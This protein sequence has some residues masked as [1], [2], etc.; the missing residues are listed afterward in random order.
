MSYPLSFCDLD[1]TLFQTVR[2][3]NSEPIRTVTT[4]KEAKP[5]SVMTDTQS[6]FFEWLS[7]TT[8]LIPITARSS[9]QFKRLQLPF[10]SWAVLAHGAVIYE[11]GGNVDKD[12]EAKIRHELS[13]YKDDL[14]HFEKGFAAIAESLLIEVNIRLVSEYDVP[15]YLQIKH[16][17]RDLDNELIVLAQA[18]TDQ[19]NL[20]GFYI[21][22][23]GNNLAIIPD[24]VN[25]QRAMEYVLTKCQI[26]R[27]TD[28]FP[29]LGF[30]DSISDLAFMTQCQWVCIPASSQIASHTLKP[31]SKK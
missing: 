2:K 28:K 1:D 23:N 21:H 20:N 25:K 3:T 11:P 5:Q 7:L 16:Q 9:E 22:L 29:V 30:G 17:N 13:I 12:W 27:K 8:E 24:P 26:K 4:D 14:L 18:A 31:Y 10:S 19:L 15:T 6:Q